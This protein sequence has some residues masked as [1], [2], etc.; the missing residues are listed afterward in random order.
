MAGPTLTSLF[1]GVFNRAARQHRVMERAPLSDPD[2]IVSMT[3]R[4]PAELK[5][6]YEGQATASGASSA[7]ALLG[8]VLQAVR[9]E[10]EEKAQPADQVAADAA[11]VLERVLHAFEAHRFNALM[12]AEF[13]RED[14][15]TMATLTDKHALLAHLQPAL[16][17]RVAD[18]FGVRRNW[19][20]NNAF[21]PLPYMVDDLCNWYKNPRAAVHRVA[22]LYKQDLDPDLYMV[23]RHG[24]NFANAFA[25]EDNAKYEPIGIIARTKHRTP[26][27]LEYFKY[28]RWFFDRWNNPCARIS[29]KAIVM[30]L[31]RAKE[32]Y[33]IHYPR[34]IELDEDVIAELSSG[35]RLP[36]VVDDQTLLR[37][38]WEPIDLVP[39][40]KWPAEREL[41]EVDAVLREYEYHKLDKWLAEV[42]SSV[43]LITEVEEGS[44]HLKRARAAT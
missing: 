41:E 11:I 43:E 26:S 39:G 8:M 15:I 16:V 17:A 5:Q 36:S 9:Q 33:R 6:F 2:E 29:L 28:E 13:F 19:L 27:G 34:A 3:L 38:S 32:G 18:H 42:G 37:G 24:A 25:K 30:W 40:P 1:T 12:I 21:N 35:R 23:R 22:E 20:M 7:S 10:T 14:G 44:D 4:I 31:V